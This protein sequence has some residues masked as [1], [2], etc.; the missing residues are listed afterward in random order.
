MLCSPL[1]A[2]CF[3]GQ[4]KVLVRAHGQIKILDAHLVNSAPKSQN[5]TESCEMS[6]CESLQLEYP[7]VSI[8]AW[9]GRVFWEVTWGNSLRACVPTSR[10]FKCV[11]S[12]RWNT[13]TI[14]HQKKMQKNVVKKLWLPLEHMMFLLSIHTGRSSVSS[15]FFRT[16][17]TVCKEACEENIL[18]G[19]MLS[20]R[21]V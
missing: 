13:L 6:K 15:E 18:R 20:Q 19:R 3:R 7:V 14:K 16:P 10:D 5:S 9:F 21:F 1:S 17:T 8:S 12:E 4:R 2:G 11:Q